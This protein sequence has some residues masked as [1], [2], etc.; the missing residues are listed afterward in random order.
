MKA[1][2]L[3]LAGA[4]SLILGACA[5]WDLLHGGVNIHETY[6]EIQPRVNFTSTDRAQL[7]QILCQYQ[8]KL[9]KIKDSDNG[10]LVFTQGRLNDIFVRQM[11]LADVAK[12]ES[13]GVSYSAVQIGAAEHGW[14]PP[15]SPAHGWHPPANPAHGWHPPASPA[16]GW[17]PPLTEED[18][19]QC[20]EMVRRVTPIL[21]KYS[22]E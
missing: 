15:S 4:F 8:N 16:H 6:V 14:H 19:R 10:K 11:F 18:L 3:V 17:H 9:Y 21:K 13:N 1:F 7:D 22:Q 20:R 12:A 5:T 2:S